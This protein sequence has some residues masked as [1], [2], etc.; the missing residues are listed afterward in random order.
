MQNGVNLTNALVLCITEGKDALESILL[1]LIDPASFGVLGSLYLVAGEGS[2]SLSLK[3][4]ERY[5]FAKTLL[6]M[7]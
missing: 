7:C 6:L 2:W 1:F 5:K 3:L 4:R